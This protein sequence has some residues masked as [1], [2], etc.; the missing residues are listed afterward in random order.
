MSLSSSLYG[1]PFNGSSAVNCGSRCSQ[2]SFSPVLIQLFLGRPLLFVRPKLGIVLPG[3]K[4]QALVVSSSC[5]LII[6][7]IN[8]LFL[9]RISWDTGIFFSFLGLGLWWLIARLASL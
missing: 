5:S 4:V 6:L 8:S 9:V 3:Q 1:F 7:P 2:A